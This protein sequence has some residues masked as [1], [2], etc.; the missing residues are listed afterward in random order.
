M[1]FDYP[2]VFV[3]LLVLLPIVLLTLRRGERH[4]RELADM[5]RAHAP[6][7]VVHTLRGVFATLFLVAVISVAARPQI[8]FSRGADLLFVVDV[9]RSMQA[10]FSCGEPTFLERAKITMR[11]TIAALPEARFGIFAFDRFAFPVTQLTA[12]RDYLQEVLDHGLYTGLM[13]DATT[14]EIANALGVVA[15]K[16]QRLEAIYGGVRHVILLSDGHVTG[17]YRRRL[18]L[19]LATLR[20]A[21]VHVSTV[22]IGNRADTPIADND[23]GRCLPAHIEVGG[24]KVLIPLRDDILK[25]VAAE[26]GGNYYTE[27][28]AGRLAEALRLEFDGG[29]DAAGAMPKRDVSG[30]FL[31][32]ATLAL[33]GYVYLRV[34]SMTEISPRSSGWIVQWKGNR[35][36]PWNSAPQRSP[37]RITADV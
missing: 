33:F 27:R 5:L 34:Q 6:D 26:T 22:G 11:Q 23:R 8:A 29:P 28:E 12:D 1:H 2:L 3:S 9:S 10:R 35:P 30:I 21:G 14:T 37:G 17:S 25:Y 15:G 19:P 24:D 7:R 20:D 36:K 18:E 16:I 4:N 31:L 32:I 13:L